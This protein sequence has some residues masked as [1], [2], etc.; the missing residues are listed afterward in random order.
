MRLTAGIHNLSQPRGAVL[1]RPVAGPPKDTPKP[2]DAPSGAT[3]GGMGLGDAIAA[4]T[5][6]LGVRKCGGCA[7]RQ[8][9]LNAIRLPFGR[10]NAGSGPE[11]VAPRGGIEDRAWGTHGSTPQEY[12]HPGATA[13]GGVG[14][15]A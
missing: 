11:P 4:V 5:D 1:T 15:A 13:P 2:Q 6:A 14:G 8:I 10:R 12:H 3:S 7:K 9:A